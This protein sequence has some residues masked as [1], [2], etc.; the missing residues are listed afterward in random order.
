M[1]DATVYDKEDLYQQYYKYDEDGNYIEINDVDEL[2]SNK[3]SIEELN[4]DF[5]GKQVKV[6]HEGET[7]TGFIIERKRN[8]DGSLIGLSNPNPKDNHPV[9]EIQFDD[10][11]YS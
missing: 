6:P 2:T 8:A 3:L 1:F 9:Y 11:S 4:D 7:K 10:G 5:K